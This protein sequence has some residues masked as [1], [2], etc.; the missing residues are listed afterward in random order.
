MP[1]SYHTNFP[2]SVIGSKNLLLFH[3]PAESRVLEFQAIH[4]SLLV[5]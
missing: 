4:K 2:R 1:N 3:R 5:L